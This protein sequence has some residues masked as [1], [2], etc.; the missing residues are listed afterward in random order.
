[1]VF[2]RF[3]VVAGAWLILSVQSAFSD[4]K[5]L[6]GTWLGEVLESGTVEQKKFDARRWLTVI[7]PNRTARYTMRFYQGSQV[8]FEFAADMEWTLEDDVW[9]LTCKSAGA[10]CVNATYRI[11]IAQDEL[12]YTDV[13]S[14]EEFRMRKV[15]TGHQLP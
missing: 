6:I 13:R 8:Q 2:R 5:A 4:E 11:T 10:G 9:R 3:V 14:R 7:E 15:P 1:M 12:R